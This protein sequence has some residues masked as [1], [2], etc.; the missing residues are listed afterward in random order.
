MLKKEK[1]A[2]TYIGKEPMF[3]EVMKKLTL[4]ES[5]DYDEKTY[6]LACAILFIRH[7]EKD[8]RYT[9]YADISYY[10]ILKY[11]LSADDYEPLFDFCM[12]FGFYPVAK[13][14][15]EKGF[16]DNYDIE[17]FLSGIQLDRF[18][19][20]NYT[21]TLEQYVQRGAF[22]KSESLERSY[23]A[24][25]SFG[26]S[27]LI[28]DAIQSGNIDNAKIVIVV[29]TKSLLM[30]TYEMIRR[31]N[32]NK[33]IIIHDEMYNN[34]D[35]VI[36][37]FTQERAL[38]FLRREDIFFDTVFID[39]AHNL[40]KDDSRSVLLSRLITKNRSKNRNQR[41]IYLSPLVDD[42]NNLKVDNSQKISSHIIDF[43]IKEPEV[44]EYR[45]DG[46]AF[47]YNR[48]VNQFYPLGSKGSIFDYL[49]LN[50]GKK[51]FLYNYRPIKIEQL[52]S[53]LCESLP[54]NEVS[55]SI[56]EMEDVL[57]K[58]VHDAFYAIKYLKYGVVY[59][60]GKLPD[61]IKEYLE[62]KFKTL[63]ELK[64]IIA[65]SVILEGMNLPIDTLFV[66]N[67]RS[68]YGKDLMNL[69]GRVNRL[70]TIF[71][72]DSG[73]LDLLIPDVHFLNDKEYNGNKGNMQGKIELLRSRVFLDSVRNPTLQ[74]FDIDNLES[75]KR[76]NE[77]YIKKVD[78]IKE[79][80]MLIRTHPENE[81]EKVK[82]YLIESGISDFYSDIAPLVASFVEKMDQINRGGW[83]AGVR[84]H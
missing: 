40:L 7:Y 11:S 26:K 43:N 28:I 6:I 24:P 34:E 35:S 15:L 58:E 32:L 19:N 12:N 74:S 51:N 54:Q 31:A 36:A 61:L 42:V 29:P 63:P 18:S 44:Y 8:N 9:S 75:S 10:I 25:T 14:I 5:L 77:N 67:T 84:R 57:K 23:L 70:N 66:L 65:N 80:E 73:R 20:E 16:L 76:N 52:A 64:Y 17:N 45:N 78:L 55:Y 27:A 82:L 33:K 3:N 49:K 47:K 4:G 37:I 79:N 22:L 21:E 83:L 46:N 48:F 81:D 72:S 69:I 71:S 38:R 68:L 39:E 62:H 59:L 30:Q 2:L 60:H 1:I 50:S 13:S 53:D 41:V 56:S